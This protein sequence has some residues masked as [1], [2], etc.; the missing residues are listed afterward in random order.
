MKSQ[1]QNKWITISKN[2]TLKGINILAAMTGTDAKKY[3]QD[4]VTNHV[5]EQVAAGN[6]VVPE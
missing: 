4:L 2:P 5:K 3:I 6:I 1:T